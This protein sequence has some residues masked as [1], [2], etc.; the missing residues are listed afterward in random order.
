MVLAEYIWIDG[1]DPSPLLRSKTKV[2]KNGETPP[3]W[4]FDG[5]STKQA[6]GTNS[7][8]VLRPVFVTHDP[9]RGGESILVLCEVY[10]T[11][12]T[13]HATNKR[14]ACHATETANKEHECWFGLEQEYTLM[15]NGK[16]LGFPEEG[17]P[18]PQGDYYCS[19]GTGRIFG[20][21]VVETH[22][23]YCLQAG[24]N[25]SGVN[26]E[27]CPGQWEFQVG[28]CGAVEVGDQ[29]WVARYLLERTA[30]SYGVKVSFDPKPVE[31]DWNGAGCHTNFSTKNMR[32]SYTACIAAAEALGSNIDEHINNY[33]HGIERRLTGEH[34]TCSH[35]DF[36]IGV[37]D[38]T[39][40]IRIPW[41]VEKEGKGYIEDRRPNA[42]CDPYVVSRIITN[43]ICHKESR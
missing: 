16:P 6:S 40:S 34:E 15:S 36:K 13:P 22:L 17:E 10:N 2:L 9:L 21:E 19:A 20:R 11:D 39:A 8:C 12:G 18:D 26:A 28:P 29:L 4:G 30:E 32:E 14:V 3:L 35:Q 42:N 24:L 5:S 31:G 25:I 38:R 27:V 37:S 1:T 43:T 33:G 7:D 41:Q 23:Y